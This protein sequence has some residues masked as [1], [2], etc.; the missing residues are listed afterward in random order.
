M[1]LTVAPSAPPTPRL[2]DLDE[3]TAT[4]VEDVLDVAAELRAASVKAVD[5]DR[6]AADRRS[7]ANIGSAR[8][9][10]GYVKELT[11]RIASRARSAGI[12]PDDLLALANKALADPKWLAGRQPYQDAA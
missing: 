5:A 3:S 2:R 6:A 4:A 1:S 7:L 8:A 11:D 10:A 12:E 9:A